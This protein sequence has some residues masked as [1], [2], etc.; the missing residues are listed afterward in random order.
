MC[1]VCHCAEWLLG[2]S[3]LPFWIA[4]W[5]RYYFSWHFTCQEIDSE[6]YL[7]QGSVSLST[8]PCCMSCTLQYWKLSGCYGETLVVN[9]RIQL[10]WASDQDQA[11][12]SWAISL[13]SPLLFPLFLSAGRKGYANPYDIWLDNHYHTS[14]LKKKNPKKTKE[15]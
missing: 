5:S 13:P 7:V 1:S 12:N 10:D 6:M 4:L 11:L 8:G 15:W 2:L 3:H 14:R 9:G